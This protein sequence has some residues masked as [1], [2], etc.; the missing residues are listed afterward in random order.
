MT[1]K[2]SADITFSCSLVQ[3]EGRQLYLNVEAIN[4]SKNTL[5]MIASLSQKKKQPYLLKSEGVLEVIYGVNA[6]DPDID[7]FGVEIPTTRPLKPGEVFKEHVQIIPLM[8]RDHFGHD[9][10]ETPLQGELN[11]MCRFAFMRTPIETSM[12]NA[13]SLHQI[14]GW[15]EEVEPIKLKVDLP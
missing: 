15:L 4:N 12:L 2:S 14:M 8:Q 9:L 13:I 10:N 7:Y 3:K 6:Q 1:S 5:H 11:V